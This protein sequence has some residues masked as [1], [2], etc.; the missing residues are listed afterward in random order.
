MARPSKE[1]YDCFTARGKQKATAM[2]AAPLTGSRKPWGTSSRVVQTG[3]T[4]LPVFASKSRFKIDAFD[5]LAWT[6]ER[7]LQHPKEFDL[8]GFPE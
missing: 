7:H 1:T 2:I 6:G 4:H 3:T 8:S 5:P